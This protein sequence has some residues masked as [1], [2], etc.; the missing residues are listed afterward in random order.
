MKETQTQPYKCEAAPFT[1]DC[2]ERPLGREGPVAQGG[3]VK[4]L[5]EWGSHTAR[6]GRNDPVCGENES[7][8]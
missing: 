8:S 7:L 1:Q 4:L 5:L 2:V 3:S 6:V